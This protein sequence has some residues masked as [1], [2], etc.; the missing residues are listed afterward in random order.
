MIRE[1]I[2]KAVAGH[3][4]TEDEAAATMTEIMTEGEASPSQIG[5]LLIAR[6]MKGESVDEIAGMVRV[7]REK[8]VRV[9]ASTH[10]TFR[11]PRRWSVQEQACLLLNTAILASRLS[12]V[13]RMCLERS[14]RK[15]N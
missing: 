3:D 4:L 5:A 10:S 14:A 8:V 9:H 12:P 2:A 1:A 11:P 7:M 15:L 6:R 13:L